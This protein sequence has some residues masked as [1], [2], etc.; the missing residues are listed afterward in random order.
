MTLLVLKITLSVLKTILF[1]E[2]GIAALED[3]QFDREEYF[4]GIEDDFVELD[5]DCGYGGT[6][7]SPQHSNTEKCFD[8]SQCHAGPD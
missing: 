8:R 7:L 6:A 3:N 2:Y 4:V 5:K 1:V